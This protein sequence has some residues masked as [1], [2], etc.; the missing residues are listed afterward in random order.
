MF[1]REQ[2]K[3]VA[4][5]CLWNSDYDYIG[6]TIEIVFKESNTYRT[7]EIIELE[8]KNFESTEAMAI[9]A[10][11][12]ANEYIDKYGIE[13]Y[14]PSPDEWSRDCPNWWEYKLS[15]KCEECKTP[16]IPTDS[17]YLPKEVCYPC[18]LKR[19]RNKRIINAE[20]Y[21]DGVTMYLSKN[22]EYI[23]IG[24]CSNFESFTISPFIKH[25]VESRLN[26]EFINVIILKKSDILDLNENLKQA[27]NQKLESYV[28]PLID[29]Q[30]KRFVK[31]YKVEYNGTEYE[32]A[33]KFNNEH[34]KISNLIDSLKTNQKALEEDYTY[35]IYF[36]NGITHR[37]DT[38]LRFINYINKGITNIWSIKE[39]YKKIL[40]EIEVI[41]T[42]EKLQTIGCVEITGNEVTI[43]KIGKNIV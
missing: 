38:I 35:E 26:E 8:Y 14:F 27:L 24:Y 41:K 15:P 13:L 43:T 25:K 23:N 17:D 32:L 4:I 1:N 37:D 7:K 2:N 9:E 29:D 39:H 16:I 12:I 19:E 21:D 5:Q 31:T 30:M 6:L 10:K 42:I 28:K 34:N 36:K 11:K 20:P 3:P 40:T 18:H 33:D 22:D